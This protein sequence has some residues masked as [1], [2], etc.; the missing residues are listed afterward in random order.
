MTTAQ[1][2][3]LVLAGVAELSE[4]LTVRRTTISQWHSRQSTNKF[5]SPVADLAM[6]PVWDQDAV[7][8]WYKGYKPL[9]NMRKVGT[10]PEE[11][12]DRDEDELT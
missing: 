12:H 7:V 9:R 4:L 8:D 11:Y 10:L 3:R 5:P 1:K 2:T 6:G